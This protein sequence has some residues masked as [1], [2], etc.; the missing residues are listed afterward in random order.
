MA[1][2]YV[3]NEAG[4]F[5]G[6]STYT[7]FPTASLLDKESKFWLTNADVVLAKNVRLH[8][9]YAFNVKTDDS[10]DYD[11]LATVSLNYNF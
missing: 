5:F 4:A 11:D 9:E 1:A 3:K 6:G 8:G 7:A 10:V 2:Q